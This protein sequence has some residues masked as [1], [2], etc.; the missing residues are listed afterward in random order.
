MSTTP[1]HLPYT[2]H[3]TVES[4]TV[5]KVILITEDGDRIEW[6]KHAFPQAILKGAKLTIAIVSDEINQ[7]EREK[8]AKQ[9]LNT[10]LKTQE[11]PPT[12]HQ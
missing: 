6:P 11:E 1:N 12:S 10:L 7:K 9:I 3:V 5:Q 2:L 8:M 4:E